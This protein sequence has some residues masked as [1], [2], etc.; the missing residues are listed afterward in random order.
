MTYQ[1]RLLRAIPGGAH[2]YSRGFDQYPSNAP[3]ILKRGD[4]AYVF[5]S[6]ENKFLDYGMALRAVNIGYANEQIANAAI[7]Q[8]KFGNN[9][10]R[11]SMI[12]LEAAEMLIN[13]IDSVDMVK[14][15]K[16]GSTATTAAVKL[17]RAY[18]GKSMVARCAEHPF[19]SYDDWFI[20]STELTLGIL[21]ETI[22]NTKTFHYNDLQSLQNLFDMYPNKFACVILEPATLEHPKDDFLQKVRDLC[23]KNGAVFIL[24]EMITGFRWHLKGAQYYYNVK[25]DICTFGKAMANG[26]SVAAVAGKREIMELGSIE[27]QGR[28]RL[29]LLSTTHG[30]EMSGLGAFVAT[31]RFMQENDVVGH[32]WQYGKRLVLAMN[33]LAKEYEVQNSFI[34]GGI[35]CSPYFLTL[36]K[37]GKNSM[38]LRTL[39]LQEMIKN[40]VLMPCLAFSYSHTEQE[41]ELTKKALKNTFEIYKKA[42]NEGYEKYLVGDVVKP[43]FRKYN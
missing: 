41:L 9:L 3:Q 25:P 17:A 27:F 31:M 38:Q 34:A 32:M 5:D 2:T 26:F 11:P 29:F 12:E 19:F 18:T 30:A 23:H 35:E 4:G 24:D 6:D 8:I 37:D 13:L 33:A 28:E 1:D 40:G 36:D 20:G 39:F 22:K 43:V 21:D 7:K 16:N 15:T 42:L 10:T 14:F